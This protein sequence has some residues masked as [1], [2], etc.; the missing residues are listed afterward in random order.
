MYLFNGEILYILK[1]LCV[2]ST[3]LY[4]LQQNKKIPHPVYT[5]R[6]TNLINYFSLVITILLEVIRQIKIK[7]IQFSK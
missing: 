5:I 7:R 3:T 6:I 2:T 1:V 4:N